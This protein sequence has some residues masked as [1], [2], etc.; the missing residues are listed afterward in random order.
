MTMSTQ[1]LQMDR[2]QVYY[3][4]LAGMLLHWPW[5]GRLCQTAMAHGHILGVD[6]KNPNI[7]RTLYM[8]DPRMLNRKLT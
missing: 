2:I 5:I 7:L 6:V 3:G 4:D 8:E 1:N